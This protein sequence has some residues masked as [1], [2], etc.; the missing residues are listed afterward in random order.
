MHFWKN[1]TNYLFIQLKAKKSNS[2]LIT[3]NAQ[4]LL[5]S[6]VFELNKNRRHYFKAVCYAFIINLIH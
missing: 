2:S 1:T 3:H 5:N 4:R 6:A